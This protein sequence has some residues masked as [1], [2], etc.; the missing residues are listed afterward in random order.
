MTD[1]VS[2]VRADVVHRNDIPRETGRQ[3]GLALTYFRITN[4]YE[5]R[6]IT[7]SAYYRPG[8]WLTEGVVAGLCADDRWDVTAS[9]PDITIP[10]L[11]VQLPK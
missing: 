3:V 7:N 1:H 5:V 10:G 2:P 9:A 4:S 11:P 6:S 8:D